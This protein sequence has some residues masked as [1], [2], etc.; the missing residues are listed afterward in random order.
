MLLKILVEINLGER[1]SDV[2][3]QQVELV[4]MNQLDVHNTSVKR[5]AC[6][7]SVVYAHAC[8]CI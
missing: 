4:F 1:A 2:C 7:Q 6:M 5:N 3:K 8:T